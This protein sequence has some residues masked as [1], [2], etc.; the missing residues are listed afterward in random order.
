MSRFGIV[1]GGMLGMTLAWELSK[2][3]HDVTIFEG[4]PRC[5]GLAA[6]WELGDVVWD[7]FYHVTLLSDRMLI[8]LLGELGLEDELRWNTPGTGF[9]VDGS[10]Y[11]FS[12]TLDYLKFPPLSLLQKMRLGGTIVHASR[13]R[14]WEPL[15][16]ITAVDWLTRLCGRGTVDRIWLP[17]L[18]AKL[19]PHA[20]RASAAFIWA[21]IARMYAARSS[22][23]GRERFGYVA[24]GYDQTLRR[25]EQ[26]LIERGVTIRT[27]CPVQAVEAL[28]DGVGVATSAELLR[29][30]NV[31]VTLAAPLAARICPTL[32]QRE[33][34]LCAGVEYQGIVCASAL[35][36]SPL[37]PYYITNIA[38]ATMPFTAVIEMTALVDRQEFGGKSLVYLPKYVASDDPAL[39]LSDEEIED[40]F[41]TALSR[42]HPHFSRSQVR[43]FRVARVPHVFP[44]PTLNYSDRLPPIQ[45]SVPGLFM[46]SSANIVN[47][48]L[49]VNET[50]RLA[51]RLLPTLGA[52][53][54]ARQAQAVAV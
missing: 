48:T 47:G 43:A 4:G 46:T 10:M 20:H 39:R 17:L 33:R 34:A 51:K 40:S 45:T 1:G 44:I 29:F 27:S 35:I 3:G 42:M 8:D 14:D 41:L 50:V 23:V 30:D 22:G 2:E 52:A 28:P 13:I 12:G 54:R 53:A 21:I 26:R 6:P 38:D 25:F 32:T 7:R 16:R 5:G 37:T 31:V 19:G 15:E 11:P 49:N 24:G 18:R 9:F 36:D